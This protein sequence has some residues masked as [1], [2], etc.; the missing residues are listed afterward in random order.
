VNTPLPPSLRTRIRQRDSYLSGMAVLVALIGFGFLAIALGKRTL[1][2]TLLPGA[3]LPALVSG[4]IGGVTLIGVCAGLAVV[5]HGRRVEAELR[6][7]T[8]RV[9]GEAGALLDVVRDEVS[10]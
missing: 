10:R 8:D 1:A 4:C 3:Q 2:R 6:Q 5:L 9:L 7:R